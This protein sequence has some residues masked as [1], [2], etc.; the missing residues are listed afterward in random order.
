MPIELFKIA[1]PYQTFIDSLP[2]FFSVMYRPADTLEDHSAAVKRATHV[3]DDDETTSCCRSGK[4]REIADANEHAKEIAKL[5]S[6]AKG[7]RPPTISAYKYQGVP[8]QQF[9]NKYFEYCFEEMMTEER[10]GTS[11]VAFASN[12]SPKDISSYL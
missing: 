2:E 10:D 6:V 11:L 7:D 8:L 12:L 5:S 3:H 4:E 1:F 9:K